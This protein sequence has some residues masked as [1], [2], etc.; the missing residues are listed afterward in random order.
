MRSIAYRSQRFEIVGRARSAVRQFLLLWLIAAVGFL[1]FFV[2]GS[3]ATEI[4]GLE[5]LILA[6]AL[7]ALLTLLPTLLLWLLYRV[8]RFAF[9]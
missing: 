2:S 8:V 6:F 5:D 7:S 9:R 3:R 4:R 1:W